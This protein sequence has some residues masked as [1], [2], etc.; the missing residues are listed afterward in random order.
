MNWKHFWFVLTLEKTNLDEASI[1]ASI[2]SESNTEKPAI[3]S[4]EP[5]SKAQVS[6]L[7][8]SLKILVCEDESTNQKIITRLLS[9]PGHQV[10]IVSNGD[11]MLDVLEQRKFDL[12]ITDLNMSGMNGADA[13][14]LI[15]GL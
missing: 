12:V 1:E 2:P 4:I 14:K 3:A 11:E 10:E 5:I 8:K 7:A 6:T 9:L 13:L 15:D